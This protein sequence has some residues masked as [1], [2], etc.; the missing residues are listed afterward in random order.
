[1]AL[2]LV[3]Q[4]VLLCPLSFTTTAEVD[5]AEYFLGVLAWDVITKYHGLGGL[6]NSCLLLTFLEAGKSMIKVQ[7]CEDSS[8]LTDGYLLAVFSDGREGEKQKKKKKR[9]RKRRRWSEKGGGE[10]E[11]DIGREKARDTLVFCSSY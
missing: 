1:M 5:L 10:K 8:W 7:Q 6:N 4:E 9:V 3:L 11:E 2:T